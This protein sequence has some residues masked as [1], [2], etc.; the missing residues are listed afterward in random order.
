MSLLRG[1]NWKKPKSSPKPKLVCIT[2][3]NKFES[4]LQLK[5][6][7]EEFHQSGLFDKKL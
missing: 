5:F 4:A 7:S 6:H 3:G 1:M 2:C